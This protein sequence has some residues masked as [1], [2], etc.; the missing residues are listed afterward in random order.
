MRIT[1]LFGILM[2]MTACTSNKITLK[3]FKIESN[4]EII[5]TKTGLNKNDYAK[6]SL[7]KQDSRKM[8]KT[9]SWRNIKTLY[10]GSSKKIILTRVLRKKNF[11][12]SIDSNEAVLMTDL[13]KYLEFYSEIEFFQYFEKKYQISPTV[14]KALGKI[15]HRK[16]K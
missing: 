7:S 11:K 1:I 15:T 6:P 9:I 13:L 10:N 2:F 3:L 8:T 14:Y 4:G 16:G 5:S 12:L